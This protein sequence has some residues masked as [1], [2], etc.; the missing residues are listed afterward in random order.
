MAAIG[1]AFNNNVKKMRAIKTQVGKAADDF[2]RTTNT[3]TMVKA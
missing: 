3:K 2:G 1:S